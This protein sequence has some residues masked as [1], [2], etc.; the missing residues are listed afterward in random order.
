MKKS[1]TKSDS[2]L[3]AALKFSSPVFLGYQAI[4]I[5]FGLLLV[6]AGYPFWLAPLMGIF[7]YAGAGQF[8]SVGLFAAG[9]GLAE[10]VLVQLI[11]NARHIAYGF[12]MLKRFRSL[13]VYRFYLIYALTDETFALLSSLETL[14]GPAEADEGSP[15]EEG[16]GNKQ[17]R[18]MFLTA[19][20]DQCYWVSGSLIGALAG[21]LIPF[22]FD[23]IAFALSA[24]FVVLMI[25]Q[26]LRVRKPG[27][28]I[29]S[30]AAAVLAVFLL[31]GRV[32][33][34][35]AMALAFCMIQ[36][37]NTVSSKGHG[38]GEE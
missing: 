5:A 23:G 3:L 24:L 9:A 30:A 32:S 17:G 20:L 22:G 12:S 34:L 14:T 31:P 27:I 18:F 36:L 25:E 15:P 16:A 6:E 29:V 1:H 38:G 4:G 33:L 28:F 2:I 7:M 19:L 11:V 10:S 37:I 13:P 8:I 21:T 35:G 26:I